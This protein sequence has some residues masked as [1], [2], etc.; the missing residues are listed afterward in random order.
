VRGGIGGD[1]SGL[2]DHISSLLNNAF[3]DEHEVVVGRGT[4]TVDIRVSMGAADITFEDTE[5]S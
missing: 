5:G 2:G 1:L 4:A 3:S